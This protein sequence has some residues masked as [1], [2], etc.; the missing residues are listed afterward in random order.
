[1]EFLQMDQDKIL[2]LMYHRGWYPS[3]RLDFP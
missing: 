1:M 2:L 3:I